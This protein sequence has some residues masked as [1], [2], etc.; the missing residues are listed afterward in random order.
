MSSSTP[1]FSENTTHE[2]LK[3]FINSLPTTSMKYSNVMKVYSDYITHEIYSDKYVMQI[4]KRAFKYKKTT[5]KTVSKKSS[6]PKTPKPRKT[7]KAKWSEDETHALFNGIKKF[8]VGHWEEILRDNKEIFAPAG[9]VEQDL[10]IKWTRF[11]DLPE[12]RKLE[13]N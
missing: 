13:N 3:A 1:Y 11:R 2:D 9:M 4:P 6:A 8:G 7:Q 10:Y 12:W 5:Q